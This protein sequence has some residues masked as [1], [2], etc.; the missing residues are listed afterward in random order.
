MNEEPQRPTNDPRAANFDPSHLWIL[1]LAVD[2]NGT[3][4]GPGNRRDSYLVDCN[5][6]DVC[7]RDHENE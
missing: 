2:E 6:P 1:G 4:T 3:L 7:L 5:C